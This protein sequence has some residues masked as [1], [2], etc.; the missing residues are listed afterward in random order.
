MTYKLCIVLSQLFLVLVLVSY[1]LNSILVIQSLMYT[2]H[3]EVIAPISSIIMY[4]SLVYSVS[5]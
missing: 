4:S 2:L 5:L 3:G 1:L